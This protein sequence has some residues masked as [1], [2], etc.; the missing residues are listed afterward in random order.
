MKKKKTGKYIFL[1][2][3]KLLSSVLVRILKLFHQ[4]DKEPTG[5][6]EEAWCVLLILT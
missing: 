5:T 3:I 1:V 6:L 4:I 2:N